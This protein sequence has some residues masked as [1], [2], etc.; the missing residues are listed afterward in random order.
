MCAEVCVCV[1]VC[2]CNLVAGA[3]FAKERLIRAVTTVDL[4]GQRAR[5]EAGPGLHHTYGRTY[6]SVH[7]CIDTYSCKYV[8]KYVH[9]YVRICVC[10]CIYT[11]SRRMGASSGCI[12]IYVRLHVCMCVCIYM[13]ISM[14]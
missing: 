12:C 4:E 7:I 9:V 2:V 5:P 13:C 3:K 1:C 11:V 8:C 14:Q 10:L 6:E